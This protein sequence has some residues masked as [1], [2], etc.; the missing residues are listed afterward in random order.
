M[1]KHVLPL[2]AGLTCVMFAGAGE[3]PDLEKLDRAIRKEPAYSC[4][5]PLYGLLVFGPRAE[6]HVWIVFDK[7]KKA[8]FYDTLYIDHNAD[9]DLTAPNKRVIAKDGK[10]GSAVFELPQFKD[11]GNG[12]TH[13]DFHVKLDVG[14]QDHIIA[15]VHLNWRG[16]IKMAGGFPPDPGEYMRLSPKRQD[17]TVLWFQGDGPFRFQRWYG[18]QLTIDGKDDFKVFLGQI[19]C[20]P[21]SFCAI[22]EHVLPAGEAV[23]ATLVYTSKEGE[24][25]HELSLLKEQ[26]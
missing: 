23:L 26:C 1:W 9:G 17:A 8:G 19:G 14:E 18:S 21:S 20:G 16:K 5:E 25:R 4:K 15:M 2:A 6:K 22:N 7:S 10:D 24:E 13:S 3:L 11:P 12:A